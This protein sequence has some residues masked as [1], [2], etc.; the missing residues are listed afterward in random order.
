MFLAVVLESYTVVRQASLLGPT[1]WAELWSLVLIAPAMAPRAVKV[2]LCCGSRHAFAERVSWSE[3]I[4][5]AQTGPLRGEQEISAAALSRC[6]SMPAADAVALVQELRADIVELGI[7][8]QQSSAPG[9]SQCEQL[10]V[11]NGASQIAGQ[12][13]PHGPDSA[14]IRGISFGGR[15]RSTDASG[16]IGG[17]G[18]RAQQD[19]HL[20]REL[21]EQVQALRE[22]VAAARAPG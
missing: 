16:V 19:S 21:A 9:V 5:A 3:V 18:S 12:Q 8:R 1:A 15:E 22:V 17:Q 6:L 10:P 13:A 11:G 2:A 14:L 7:R 4:T 20:L